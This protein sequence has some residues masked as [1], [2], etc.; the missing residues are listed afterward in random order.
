MGCVVVLVLLCAELLH[1]LLI[2]IELS[3]CVGGKG[4]AGDPGLVVVCG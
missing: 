1:V 3:G 4:L 2:C